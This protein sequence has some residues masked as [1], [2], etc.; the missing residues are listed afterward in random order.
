MITS[1][2]MYSL[3]ACLLPGAAAAH[4]AP[5]FC[6][7]VP[8]IFSSPSLRDAHLLHAFLYGTALLP[9]QDRDAVYMALHYVDESGRQQKLRA[10]SE[11][12]V[13]L[14]PRHL[15]PGHLLDKLPPG[16]AASRADMVRPG[17]MLAVRSEEHE[18]LLYP[19]LVTQITR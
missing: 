7:S 13:Y 15:E 14:A 12:L 10:S 1:H 19:A 17:D 8:S 4:H 18:G 6:S 9:C 3:G 16:G 5:P 11:H 2:V